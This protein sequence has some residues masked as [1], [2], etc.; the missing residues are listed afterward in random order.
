MGIRVIKTAVA[1]ILAI[2]IAQAT[3]LASPLSTGLLAVLGVDVTKKR[4]IATSV[5]RIVASVFGLLLSVGLFVWLGYHVWV[6][7]IYIL[8]LYPIL[9]RLKLK[10]GIVTSSVVMFHLYAA[11]AVSFELVV[12]EV[13]LLVVGLG[14][15]TLINVLYMPREDRQL[16]QYRL[17]L[18]ALFSRILIQLS[19]HLRDTGHVWD[20][21]ELL[22]SEELLKRAAEA[23]MRKTENSLSQDRADWSVYF[24]MRERQLEGIGRMSQLVARVYQN[25]PHANLLA[26]IF[27]GLS[28]DVK[29]AHYTGRTERELERLE[30]QFREMELP[31]TREEFEVRA[32][33]L[34]LIEELKVFLSVAKKEKRP[35]GARA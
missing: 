15:A 24:Y 10:D 25:L 33:L 4:S 31:R 23:A 32:A 22:D 7:G 16:L 18:E 30:A 29:V 34:Q 1:V 20:G 19:L 2:M 14:T 21:K 27:E 26:V 3:G 28:E 12:N 6:I 5:Q 11:R 13:A 35:V 8:L 17:E 9:N